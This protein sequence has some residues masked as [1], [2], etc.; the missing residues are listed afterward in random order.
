MDRRTFSKSILGSLTLTASGLSL[1]TLAA[2]LGVEDSFTECLSCDGFRQLLGQQY[3]IS[4]SQ[5]AQLELAGI[6][7]ASQSHPDEQFY[8]SF[9][10]TQGEAL[11]EGIYQMSSQNGKSLTLMLSPSHSRPEFMEAVINLQTSA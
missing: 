6:E 10:R 2:V 8:L 1:N 3:T 11:D 7:A 5:H 4:G 9:R